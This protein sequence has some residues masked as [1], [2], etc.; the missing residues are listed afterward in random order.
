MNILDYIIIAI[1]LFFTVKGILMGFI[2]EIASL[3]GII[4]GF[5]LGIKFIPEVTQFLAD[6]V[7]ESRF[8]PFLSFTLVFVGVLVLSNVAGWILYHFFKK[9][10]LG[11]F[12]KLMGAVF[13][14]LKTILITYFMIVILTIFVPAKAPLIANS[15]LAPWV[16]KSY[17]SIISLV[18]PDHYR[19]LKKKLIGE[20]EKVT[21]ALAG[22][23]EKDAEPE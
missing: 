4:L 15:T 3:A 11:W 16:I 17:Q 23:K 6:Y 10:F 8:L 19:N 2:R 21:K 22:E 9:V 20:K 18:S 12:D 1:L 13:A 7:P 5:W 14:V